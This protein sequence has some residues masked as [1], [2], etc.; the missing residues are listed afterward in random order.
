MCRALLIDQVSHLSVG[1][2]HLR[3]GIPVGFIVHM[4]LEQTSH[5]RL[6]AVRGIFVGAEEAD[7][8]CLAGRAPTAGDGLALADNDL[9]KQ[10]PLA[11]ELIIAGLH[12]LITLPDAHSLV[13]TDRANHVS[14]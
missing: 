11:L 10:L 13:N 9:P 2:V 7:S 1:S 6:R 5:C 8:K 3:H 12:R 14:K 4:L